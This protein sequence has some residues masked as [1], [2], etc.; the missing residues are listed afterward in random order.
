M[1][2]YLYFMFFFYLFVKIRS[3]VFTEKPHETAY[4]THASQSK[5]QLIYFP[6]KKKTF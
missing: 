5:N 6:K 3:G 2:R 4:S 1:K